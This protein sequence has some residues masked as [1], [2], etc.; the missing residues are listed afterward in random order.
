MKQI[1]FK[2][3]VDYR[4]QVLYT[5]IDVHSK[6]LKVKVLSE[7][8]SLK[9]FSYPVDGAGLSAYLQEQYPGAKIKSVY[10]AGFC[11]LGLH[12][13]LCAAGIENI[14]VNPSDVPTTDKER[15]RKSDR[16]DCSKLA[17]ALRSGQLSANYIPRLDQE[18]DRQL[19]RLRVEGLRRDHSRVSNRLKMF[20]YHTDGLELPQ[21]FAGLRVSNKLI[22]WLKALDLESQSLR[23]TLELLI[24]EL[25]LIR[26]LR[27]E[28]QGHIRRLASQDRYRDL[29]AL[30]CQIPGIGLLTAMVLMTELID[31]QRFPSLD[32]LCSY[33]GVIPDMSASGEKEQT[34]GITKRGNIHVNWVLNQAAWTAIR[35]DPGLSLAY[36]NY[37]KRMKPCTAIIRVEKKLLSRIRFVWRNKAEYEPG[38]A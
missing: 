10:E 20:L 24:A 35:L 28:A 31:I 9:S 7:Y 4:G 29:V 1:Q 26:Q 16:I 5:G 36:H 18:Q 38:L 32:K 34:R 19:V 17:L 37:R 3:K 14:V 22:N 12:R 27:L 8:C 25:E 11:G 21:E 33:C 15:R 6:S 30:L 2:K 13:Q 23:A